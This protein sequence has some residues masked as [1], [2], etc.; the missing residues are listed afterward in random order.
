MEIFMINQ[1][2]YDGKALRPGNKADVD[3]KTAQRWIK[4]G[5]AIP[6]IQVSEQK[7]P[8]IQ[9]SEQEV[10]EDG[11][12]LGVCNNSPVSGLSGD[13]SEKPANRRRKAP[14]KGK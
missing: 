11:D 1:T 14:K 3:D 6:V 7:I 5:I 13:S 9:V 12:I 8:V 10:G 2:I 4:N